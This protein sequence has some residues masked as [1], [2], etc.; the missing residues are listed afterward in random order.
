MYLSHPVHLLLLLD[1]LVSMSLFLVESSFDFHI[2]LLVC[3][4][5]ASGGD[6]SLLRCAP[7]ALSVWVFSRH[8]VMPI[9]PLLTRESE[10]RSVR[11]LRN[12]R[13]T[14]LLQCVEISRRVSGK[15]ADLV[16]LG[17]F[18]LKW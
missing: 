1:L 12:V 13:D 7:Y 8:V 6:K 11:P 10:V 2:A 18:L 9:A 14:T 17:S 15:P 5:F 3:E 4:C 16:C